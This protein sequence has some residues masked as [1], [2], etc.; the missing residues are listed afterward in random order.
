MSAARRGARGD[1]FHPFRRQ[2]GFLATGFDGRSR[3]GTVRR[4]QALTGERKICAARGGRE[5]RAFGGSGHRRC[6]IKP[7]FETV[8][9]DGSG[10]PR[11][12]VFRAPES[13][14]RNYGWKGR[15]WGKAGRRSW[16]TTPGFA[17]GRRQQL[18][19]LRTDACH[20]SGSRPAILTPRR[21]TIRG[22]L[23]QGQAMLPATG[24]EPSRCS[25]CTPNE[26]MPATVF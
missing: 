25:E 6:G 24:Q 8:Q 22:P 12:T 10:L 3:G 1:L 23:P 9:R 2:R 19:A 16:P 18:A 21:K 7:L 11:R 13:T 14:C 20:R 17:R 15:A 5:G 4:Y 26:E